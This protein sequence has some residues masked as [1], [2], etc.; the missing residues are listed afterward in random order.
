MSA[1]GIA[2]TIA[3]WLADAA[4]AAAVRCDQHLTRDLGLDSFQLMEIVVRID[5]AFGVD[6][7][8]ELAAGRRLDTVGDVTAAVQRC[9]AA[10]PPT[11]SAARDPSAG[12]P[13]FLA[14]A[15]S[16]LFA[17][18]HAAP[19]APAAPDA[20]ER[21]ARAWLFC[22]PFAHEYHQ[23]QRAL[24]HLA[25]TLAERG[26]PSLRFE[27]YGYGDSSGSLWEARIERWLDSLAE[28]GRWLLTESG[29][30]ALGLL[31]VRLGATLAAHAASRIEACDALALWNPITEP[32]RHV[33]DLR[34]LDRRTFR[35][36]SDRA[37]ESELLGARVH[38]D[39]LREIAAL[40][41]PPIAPERPPRVYLF[42]DLTRRRA[43][44]FARGLRAAR[45]SA[46]VT[47]TPEAWSWR[48]FHTPIYWPAASMEVI[49]HQLTEE[50]R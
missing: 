28:A 4:G 6:L 16:S 20:P 50:E 33:R 23:C 31:G 25:A 8:T 45:P 7:N 26:R 37:R 36:P 17:V 22:H 14:H 1:A 34:R 43:A 13:F 30:P 46:R 5:Q 18:Y 10:E 24:S 42:D 35:R 11:T 39:L 3:G 29:A 49:A 38:P 47:S 27:L 19:T 9:A 44:A 32:A 40:D 2:D 12:R 48:R 21:P 15:D 41:P